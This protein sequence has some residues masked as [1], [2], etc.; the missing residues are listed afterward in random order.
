MTLG[1]LIDKVLKPAMGVNKPIITTAGDFSYDDADED[2]AAVNALNR[3]KALRDL[4]GGGLGEQVKP[5]R[6]WA[7]PITPT[8]FT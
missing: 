5:A 8:A 4:P 7:H 1:T 2:S 6:R 3:P